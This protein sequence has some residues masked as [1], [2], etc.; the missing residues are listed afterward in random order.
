MSEKIQSQLKQN[1]TKFGVL[2]II[3]VIL[4]VIFLPL[5]I[6]N[7]IFIIQGWIYPDKVPMIFDTAPLIVVSD[8]M[9]IE[10]D[11]SGN[12]ISGAFNKNDLI[13]IKKVDP[14]TLKEGDIITYV[15][16]DGSIVTH[17]IFLKGTTEDKNASAFVMKG[18]YNTSIDQDPISYNQVVGLYKG[19]IAG[20]GG[21]ANFL[22][23]PIGV[24]VVLGLPL[25]C[26]LIIDLIKKKK[27]NQL[28]NSK[29]AELETELAQL[30]A[31]KAQKG[32]KD[33][34]R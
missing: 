6:L 12:I 17:R 15:A 13:F 19:R 16:K 7:L 22:Q 24:I 9:T 4:L 32:W 14:T 31:E 8:S 11:E 27:E 10:K 30:K 5:V 28:A 34:S 3:G 1:I 21:V 33:S 18:D 29:N 20:I 2:N 26:I 25:A 23:S